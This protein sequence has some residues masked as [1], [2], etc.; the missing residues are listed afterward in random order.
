MANNT[1]IGIGENGSE[2]SCD[3]EGEA[4][5]MA[6]CPPPIT[7]CNLTYTLKLDTSGMCCPE[8]C[9]CAVCNQ[10]SRNARKR[11]STYGATA[12][13]I[14]AVIIIIGALVGVWI[15]YARGRLCCAPATKSS[16]STAFS[17]PVYEVANPAPPATLLDFS[18]KKIA[19]G[20]LVPN[21]VSNSPCQGVEDTGV[22]QV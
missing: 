1:D 21:H 18:T 17:N 19:A 22:S 10:D 3:V 6:R 2:T 16:P 20:Q 12:G 4:C 7:G 9:K 5:P 15:I 11:S 8:M 14:T 13:A